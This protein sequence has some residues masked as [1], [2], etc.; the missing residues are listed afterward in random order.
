MQISNGASSSKKTSYDKAHAKKVVSKDAS[1]IGNKLANPK[2][3]G[4]GKVDP[5]KG[6]KS[7]YNSLDKANNAQL[8]NKKYKPKAD[9]SPSAYSK[10]KA[11][12]NASKKG[13]VTKTPNTSHKTPSTS[14]KTPSTTHRTPTAHKPNVSVSK[15]PSGSI[16]HSSPKPSAKQPVSAVPKS[17]SNPSSPSLK[18]KKQDYLNSLKKNSDSFYNDQVSSLGKARDNAILQQKQTYQNAVDEGKISQDEANKQFNEDVKSIDQ[19]F[20]KQAQSTNLMAYNNGIQSSMQMLGL[21]AGDNARK[22]D[23]VDSA[24]STRDQQINDIKNRLSSLASTRDLNISGINSDYGYNV[25]QARA[26]ADQMYNNG[27]SQFQLND[28]NTTQQHTWDQQNANQQHAWDVQDA[29]QKHNWDVAN[30]NTAFKRQSSLSKSSV[31]SSG[32]GVKGALTP[33]KNAYMNYKNAQATTGLDRYYNKQ[34]S[35][36]KGSIVQRNPAL[37]PVSLN[38]NQ[39]LS[40]WQKYKIVMGG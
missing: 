35:L 38:N 23:S 30:A 11:I 9:S 39:T 40:P 4:H 22:Q 33:I 37:P 32:S 8:F 3:V 17:P 34:T 16:K 29:T 21:Q 36:N 12:E 18:Q 28:Y 2:Q 7:M 13:K 5:F 25:S 20:Y 15:K 19:S 26:Q 1:Y 6:F 31:K 27:T 24:T 10:M 14:H